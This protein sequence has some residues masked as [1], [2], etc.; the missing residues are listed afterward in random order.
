MDTEKNHINKD[1]LTYTLDCTMT[2]IENCD[3]KTS[4]IL[5]VIGVILGIMLASDYVGKIASIFKYMVDNIGFWTGIH[6]FLSILSLCGIVVGSLCLLQVLIGKTD[7]R[8]FTNKGISGNSLIFFA[9]IAKQK[10]FQDYKSKLTKCSESDWVDEII[11]QIYICSIICDQ[12]F[13]N[14]KRGLFLSA[15]GFALFAIM[16]IIGIM[17]M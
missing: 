10:T 5:G 14:Y 4:I 8:G 9:S 6:I 11:S 12:K 17:V 2:W 16:M 1:N 7:T 3:A 13:Q 15:A